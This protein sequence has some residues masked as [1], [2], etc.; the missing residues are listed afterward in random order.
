M[1]PS[2]EGWPT[3]AKETPSAHEVRLV[4][5]DTN[6]VFQYL[7]IDDLP[8]D[9]TCDIA[10]Y[11]DDTTLYS[12]C[13]QVSDLWKQLELASE[14]ESD[15]RE[16]ANWGKKL[17]AD[18]NA[19]KTQLVLFDQSNNT[20]SVDVKMDESVLERKITFQNAGVDFLF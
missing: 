4:P 13:N 1:T 3:K 8:D 5:L 20:G 15:L 14:L 12:K 2:L 18:F 11:P 16:T 19:G 10:L 9:A 17:F 7:G 6:P